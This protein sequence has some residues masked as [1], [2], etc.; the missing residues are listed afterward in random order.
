MKF[1]PVRDRV[2]VK[3]IDGETQTKSGIYIPD[4]ATEKSGQG[5]VVAVGTGHLLD[6]GTVVI[7]EVKSGDKVLFN[8]Q[9]GQTV[10]VD[11]EEYRIL[12]ESEILAVIE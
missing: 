5:N 3:E 8:H 2:I 6:N 10:K 1:N 4:T 7:L 9:S 11:G 12:R